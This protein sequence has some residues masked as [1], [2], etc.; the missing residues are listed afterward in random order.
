MPMNSLLE[1]AIA[2]HGELARWKQLHAIVADVS[3]DGFLWL[4]KGRPGALANTQ[5]V[6]QLQHQQLET[7][8]CGNEQIS[9]S[10]NKLTIRDSHGEVL[11]TRDNPRFSFDA[12]RP[13]DHWD[14][15]QLGYFN[16]Y[17]LWQYLTAPFVFAYPGFEVEEV[18]PWSED[19]EEWRVLKVTFPPTIISH[20]RVQYA[21]FGQDGLLRKQRYT[22]D[23]LGGAA[24]VNYATGYRELGGIMLPTERR[25]YGYN[26]Q[27]ERIP[28]P[29]LVSIHISHAQFIEQGDSCF[30]QTR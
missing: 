28:E 20:S 14:D 2:A 29:V 17:A 9:F 25:V 15:M 11:V 1:Y 3:V 30:L 13:E 27:L 16:S 22:V 10:P 7:Y 21:Y 12:L 26:S 23:V 24:G 5:V 19:G 8:L 6:A 4:L 18:E